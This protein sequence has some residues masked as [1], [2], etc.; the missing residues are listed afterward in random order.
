MTSQDLSPFKLSVLSKV[1]KGHHHNSMASCYESD[2]NCSFPSNK[3]AAF[4]NQSNHYFKPTSSCWPQRR[5]PDGATV[6]DFSQSIT[7]PSKSRSRLPSLPSVM[8]E[9]SPMVEEPAPKPDVPLPTNESAATDFEKRNRASFDAPASTKRKREDNLVDFVVQYHFTPPSSRPKFVFSTDEK[10][11]SPSLSTMVFANEPQLLF[12]AESTAHH[13]ATASPSD[14]KGLNTGANFRVNTGANLRDVVQSLTPIIP[15]HSDVYSSSVLAAEFD[16]ELS[17]SS[18]HD[19]IGTILVDPVEL[20]PS[21]RK[22][23][24]RTLDFVQNF[25]ILQTYPPPPCTEVGGYCPKDLAMEF[26]DAPELPSDV[27]D[28]GTILL[29]DLPKESSTVCAKASSKKNSG[30]SLLHFIQN[31]L[32]PADGGIPDSV[33][34]QRRVQLEVA[35]AEAL[36]RTFEEHFEPAQFDELVFR[37]STSLALIPAR[38]QSKD[39]RSSSS[40]DDSTDASDDSSAWDDDEAE[41]N[42]E[43]DE[44]S[45]VLVKLQWAMHQSS[46]T[47]S[48]LQEWDKANG[49]PKSHC[50]TMVNSSRSR[51]QL[52]SGL[53]L[54]KW[55]GKPLLHIPGAKVKVTRR[56]FRGTKVAGFG[57]DNTDCI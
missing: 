7:L 32:G 48:S 40:C 4:G 10:D 27:D 11:Y 26:D 50:Q 39:L 35:N 36:T 13:D 25:G 33:T 3:D 19:S 55:D 23:R 24:E 16:D 49:L 37:K 29:E 2:P 1:A 17:L 28:L 41:E 15:A 42:K 20:I 31:L 38:V 44:Q 46:Y 52:Q 14:T 22:G 30:D 51:E 53:V 54:Q 56:M 57:D 6:L 12:N 45:E 47:M 9:P 18:G 8:C 21:K 5:A 34:G 43:H